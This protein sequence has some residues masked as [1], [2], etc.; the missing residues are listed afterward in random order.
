M[1]YRSQAIYISP[2]L[3]L[4]SQPQTLILLPQPTIHLLQTPMAS[5]L[6][7]A[8]WFGA[9]PASPVLSRGVP[10]ATTSPRCLSNEPDPV[11][12]H[13]SGSV[14][15]LTATWLGCGARGWLEEVISSTNPSPWAGKGVWGAASPAARRPR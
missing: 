7:L 12:A 5:L 9:S 6:S 8:S 15:S 2:I 4:P 13:S 3:L 14:W 11:G 1:L 10:K